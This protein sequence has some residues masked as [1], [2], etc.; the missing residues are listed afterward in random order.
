MKHAF[1]LLLLAGLAWAQQPATDPPGLPGKLRGIG[2]EQRLGEP[3]PADVPFTDESGNT[4]TL[5]G[6]SHGRPVVLAMVYYNCTMLCNQILN[7]VVRGL[8]PLSLQPGKDFEVVAISIDPT[9]G[10]DVAAGK[11][12]HYVHAY[13]RT[14]GVAGWHFLTG[15]EGSIHAVADA[16]GFHY[17]YDPS[18]KFFLHASGV[19]VLTPEHRV[20]RYFYGV[21]YE[22][23]DLKLGLIEASGNR[24]GSKVD[25]I[26]LFCYHYDPTQAKYSAAVLNLLQAAAAGTLFAGVVALAF[27]WRN[28]IWKGAGRLRMRVWRL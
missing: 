2:I 13:S 22:P 19:M 27:L 18:T 24:I 8:R 15:S 12:E 28:D 3:I 7:G 9:E 4:V 10:P 1:T 11:R 14:A 21:E 23:K 5:A 16:V 25:Q 17:R 20:A 26:L 6:V